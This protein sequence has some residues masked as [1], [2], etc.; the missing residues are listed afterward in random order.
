M[1]RLSVTPTTCIG[2]TRLLSKLAN[3]RRLPR[4]S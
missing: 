4:N 1:R 3:G 2:L